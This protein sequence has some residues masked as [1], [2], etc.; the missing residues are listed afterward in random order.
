MEEKTALVDLADVLAV[1]IY[2]IM[3]Q[4]NPRAHVQRNPALTDIT[5]IDGDFDLRE[6]VRQLFLA[7]S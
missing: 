2:K 3:R 6:V 4:L 1:N 5:T 7:H